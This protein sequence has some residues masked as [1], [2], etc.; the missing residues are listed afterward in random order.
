M[1]AEEKR[2]IE[3]ALSLPDE[4]AD[5]VMGYMIEILPLTIPVIAAERDLQKST[6]LQYA[7][8]EESLNP[9]MRDGKI[10]SPALEAWLKEN[11]LTLTP[12]G[13]HMV[14]VPESIQLVEV[15]AVK[16]D[17]ATGK[18]SYRDL[19]SPNTPAPGSDT[20]GEGQ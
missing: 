13:D 8:I 12:L 11:H 16:I 5:R 9:P 2:L 4:Q 14:L 1:N 18:I 10:Y 6:K 3:L 15:Q 7:L 19:R 17:E 20:P